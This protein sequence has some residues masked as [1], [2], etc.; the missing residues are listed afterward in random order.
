MT[1][2]IK[3]AVDIALCIDSTGSMA[4]ILGEVKRA[5]LRFHD[6]LV[7]AMGEKGK[8]I[9]SLRIRVITFR[10]YWADGAAAVTESD[11]FSLPHQREEFSAFV[12]GCVADGGGDEPENGLEAVAAAIRSAWSK[13]GDRR[14]QLVIV[15][16]DASAHPL[17]KTPKPSG[18]PS[19]VPQNLD[20]LTDMWE[21]E[22][23]VSRS[24][25]RLI[26]YA[27][28]ADPWTHLANNWENSIHYPS[29]AGQ[30]MAEV[31][32]KE[33]LNAIANSV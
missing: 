4:P 2:G 7:G 26:I 29:E 17:D 9:D 12:M 10:D 14:R 16:T 32:Y 21:S 19:N 30:G 18:Y 23:F 13:T 5:A 31:T 11:F 25:K 8:T 22:T 3:Y 15:W 27:P 28:D 1:Q 6:D 24:A 33:V 20:E